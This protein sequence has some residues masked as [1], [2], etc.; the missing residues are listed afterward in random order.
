M[1][2]EK[3]SLRNENELT[4]K[5]CFNEYIDQCIIRNL[6]K[7]TVRLFSSVFLLPA[8]E[9]ERNSQNSFDS[10]SYIDCCSVSSQIFQSQHHLS[11]HYLYSP[12]QQL[13]HY[14][15][16]LRPCRIPFYFRPHRSVTCVF[17]IL[18]TLQVPIFH[19]EA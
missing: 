1:S 17:S 12:L 9:Q 8:P 7:E 16:Q 5:E 4:V 11:R 19:T 13:R 18:I 15:G 6:S 10:I 14:Y 3:L 2:E